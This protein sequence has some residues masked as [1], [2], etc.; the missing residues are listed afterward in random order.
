MSAKESTIFP[1]FTYNTKIAAALRAN[2]L[3]IYGEPFKVLKDKSEVY[4]MPDGRVAVL[5]KLGALRTGKTATSAHA[6]AEG[7][8]LHLADEGVTLL[9]KAC[10]DAARGGSDSNPVEPT[11]PTF[12]PSQGATLPEPPKEIVI[13]P[14][15][16]QDAHAEP[17]APSIDLNA[18]YLDILAGLANMPSFE[19]V[20]A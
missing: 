19:L 18:S 10:A 2:L 5:G 12:D 14:E 11:A 1:K 3:S 8:R 6:V 7:T 20:H 16:L 15:V 4:R 17:A 13:N 9:A